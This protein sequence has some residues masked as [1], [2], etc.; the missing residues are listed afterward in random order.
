MPEKTCGFIPA[1]QKPIR[2]PSWLK[3]DYC[4][5]EIAMAGE[6]ISIRMQS[7]GNI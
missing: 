6:K 7:C 4:H 3:S 5:P 2:M 1:F